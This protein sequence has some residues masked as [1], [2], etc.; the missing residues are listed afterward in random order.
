MP[1]LIQ[2]VSAQSTPTFRYDG[3]FEEPTPPA[4][5]GQAVIKLTSTSA[6]F[7]VGQTA[8]CDIEIASDQEEISSYTISIV[9]D[10]S[11]LEVVDSD[12]ALNGT[13]INFVD[14]F[15]SAQTNSADNTAGTIQL[16]ATVSDTAQPINRRIA[17]ITFRAKRTGTS[18]ISVNKSQSA[19]NNDVNRDVLASTTS[20]NF[21]ISGQT[22]QEEPQ[23][24]PLPESGLADTL[25]NAGTLLTAL[26]MLFVGV[27]IVV[28][29]RKG[30]NIDF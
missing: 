13:Q 21:T 27:K 7:Q 8:T 25:A 2:R 9:F 16:E 29:K 5:S 6:S 18:V 23:E 22:Q 28:D 17:Q 12:L 1:R 19:V 15:S 20:V 30:K 11:V 3:P 24:E 4:P 14:S 10:A 26:L